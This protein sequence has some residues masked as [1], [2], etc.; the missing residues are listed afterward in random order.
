[1]V[2]KTFA[3]FM[4]NRLQTLAERVYLEA[5][6]GF[7]AERSTIDM[8]FSLRQLLEKCREQRRPLYIAFI[9]MTKAL[10]LV[11]R[12]ELLIL[13]HRIGC[14]PSSWGWSSS[15]MIPPRTP[16]PSKVASNKGASSR[17]HFLASCSPC[18]C[19]MPSMNPK[20]ASTCTPE[21]LIACS[22]WH[23]SEPR[24]RCAKS[25]SGRCSSLMTPPSQLTLRLPSRS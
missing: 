19:V 17:R 11:S 3:R 22:T 4:L 12:S 24:L 7:R 6:S 13:L 9:D 23:A 14:P 1:M 2:G 15:M 21:A 20:R 10:D 25:S 8:I 16:S 18:C 5:Q